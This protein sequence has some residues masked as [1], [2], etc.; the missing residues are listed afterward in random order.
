MWSFFLIVLLKQ[1]CLLGG[2][3]LKTKYQILVRKNYW[4]AASSSETFFVQQ[5]CHKTFFSNQKK[6]KKSLFFRSW[7]EKL[8][9]ISQTIFNLKHRIV[10]TK[11]CHLHFHN[12]K[13][14]VRTNRTFVK[15]RF[16]VGLKTMYFYKSTL[17]LR[18]KIFF[19]CVF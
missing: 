8:A 9:Y 18:Q 17:S 4:E 14:D 10:F 13:T 11:I 15:Y 5:L 6:Q 16:S 3:K 19:L 1:I 7:N 2:H 12:F